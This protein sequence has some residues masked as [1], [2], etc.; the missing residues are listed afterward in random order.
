VGNAALGGAKAMLISRKVRREVEEMV[1]E[2]GYIS[3]AA[4]PR[5]QDR[6][7]EALTFPDRTSS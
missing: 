4:S 6:F 3:L 1:G 2:I 5:F 7:I